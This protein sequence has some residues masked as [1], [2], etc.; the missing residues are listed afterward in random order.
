MATFKYRV[1]DSKGRTTEGV[2]DG[3]D[4]FVV[5]RNFINEGKV[6]I[7]IEEEN[8]QGKLSMEYLNLALSRVKTQDKIIFAK[9]LGAMIKAG[10][11]LSRALDV[12]KR[13]TKNLKLKKAI[14]DIASDI[15][16]GNSLSDGMKKHPKI[17]STLFVSMVRSGEEAGNLAE[18][19]NVVSD[20]L[21]K[22]YNLQK[23][24]KGAMVYPV[25]VVIIMIL[26]GIL[27][28]VYV[29]PTLTSTF[30]ELQIELPLSTQFVIL[31]SDLLVEHT[32][33][34]LV[35]LVALVSSFVYGIK[36]RAGKRLAEFIFL[37][38]PFVGKITRET[39]SAM[40]ARTLSSLLSSG[41]E[42]VEAIKITE[43]VVQNSYFKKVL[44]IAAED[45]QK[46][47]VLSKTFKEN[48]HLYP[49]LVGEMI[50]VGEETGNLPTM[51]FNVAVFYEDE[52]D[53]M[54]KNITAIIEPLMMVFIGGA[55]GFFAVSM[56]SPMYSLSGAF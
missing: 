36:T 23:K 40:T 35:G 15:N 28:L 30:K 49:I 6:V 37:K 56:I 31:A 38:L 44:V 9:N 42:I 3:E 51:L 16:K 41:V 34:L 11:S 7:S 14:T 18:S 25:V 20:H 53:S 55:V 39:N 33:L 27:M 48:E 43:G 45:I 4:R 21:E 46:G 12:F 22:S 32:I 5:S 1:Q 54:T 26:I 24:I 2:I 50:E 52:V 19:L 10:L 17:F 29:V 13:Q 47:G 8:S